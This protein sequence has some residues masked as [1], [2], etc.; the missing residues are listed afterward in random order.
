[1]NF[2]AIKMLVGDRAKYIGIIFG[3]TFASLLITQQMAIFVG[4]WRNEFYSW[5]EGSNEFSTYWDGA[6]TGDER[7][8]IAEVF[9]RYQ[10]EIRPEQIAWWRWYIAEQMKGDEML[11][12]QE[13]PPTEDYAFQLSGSKFFSAERVNLAYQRSLKEPCMYFR[14]IF[15]LNFEDTQFVETTEEN[16]EVTIWETPVLQAKAGDRAGSYALGC[17]PAYGSSEWADEFAACMLRCYA[18]KIVQVAEIGTTTWTDQ[19]FAWAIAHLCGWYGDVMLNLEMQGPGGA[20]FNELLNLKRQAGSIP[21]TDARAGAFD[22]IGRIRDYLWKKQ[23]SIHGNFAYQW[24]TNPKEKIR[25][26]STLRSYFEREIIELNSPA[27]IQQFRNIHRNGDQIGGEGRA[28]DDR[29]IALAIAT[30]AWN[31]W[32]MGEMQ[33]MQR[34][35]AREN[36]GDEATK[37]FTPVENSVIKYLT[38]NGINFRGLT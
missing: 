12:L 4:W 13:M 32:I 19:Q 37:I 35:Y 34:T 22:V 27:C 18:D 30:V 2:V 31:D 26:M 8:W 28:K 15:G 6:P 5:P 11:A 38:A 3:L 16:A 25:M 21:P 7:V 23:D 10:I 33:A 20:V 14:Y 29:V 9:E 24:Q 36:R 17:D 1:M